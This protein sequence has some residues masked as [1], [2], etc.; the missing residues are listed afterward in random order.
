MVDFLIEA[1]K[2]VALL[3]AIAVV[4]VIAY[5]FIKSMIGLANLD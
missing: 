3:G 5:G 2:C 4:V 1:L